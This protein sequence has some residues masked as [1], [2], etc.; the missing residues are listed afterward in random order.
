MSGGGS[1]T[2]SG[3]GTLTLT[4][5]NTYT[6]ATTVSS[7][8]LSVSSAYFA[9]T[10]TVSVATGAVLNLSHG[11][12]DI[13]GSLVLGGVVK[14]NGLYDSTTPGGFITGSGKIQVGAGVTGY[15]SWKT[16]NAGGQ[17]ANL[18][19]DLDGVS[20]GVEYFFNAAAGFTATP[21]VVTS[22]GSVRTVTWPNGGNIPFTDYG[23]Q[24]VVQTSIDLVTWQNVPAG[25]ANLSNVS[26]SVTYTLTG[27]GKFFVRL[28]VTPN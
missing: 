27:T 17:T 18:D 1:L 20:N 2:K 14:P 9:D 24:F 13:V 8:T 10:S 11:V 21:Q 7:G 25:D 19:W 15:A 22:A 12:T 16:A 6:G 3:S 28:K 4:G 26:G 23:T 5:S